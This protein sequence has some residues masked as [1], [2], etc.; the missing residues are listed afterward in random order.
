MPASVMDTSVVHSSDDEFSSTS[1]SE[2]SS[3][4]QWTK[5]TNG[6]TKRKKDAHLSRRIAMPRRKLVQDSLPPS[7]APLAEFNPKV[8][9][10]KAPAWDR[11]L[12]VMIALSTEYPNL[13]IQS[14]RGLTRT[15]IRAKDQASQDT[16][17]S[18]TTLQNKAV[19]FAPQPASITTAYGIVQRVPIAIPTALLRATPSVLEAERMSVWSQA[20][21]ASQPT[22]S[23]KIR[24]EGKLPSKIDIGHLGS[25]S[26][27]PYTPDPIRCYRCQR[28][29]H[30]TRTCHQET[31]TCGICS[32]PHRTT[33]CQEKRRT[34][35]VTPRCSNCKGKH[36]TASKAC[37]VRK[38]RA[39][40]L[41]PKLGNTKQTPTAAKP[42]KQLSQGFRPSMDDFPVAQQAHRLNKPT[43][44]L[45]AEAP[46]LPT[47]QVP[48]AQRGYAGAAGRSTVH[49][50]NAQ[51]AKPARIQKVA[52]TPAIPATP[53]NRKTTTATN[54]TSL[55]STPK[56]SATTQEETET[57]ETC[58]KLLE[59]LFAQLDQLRPLLMVRQKA[60]RN[61]VAKMLSSTQELLGEIIAVM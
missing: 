4:E 43:T 47:F 1:G 26:V 54:K 58:N 46:V 36:S 8:I 31:S 48:S 19:S 37:P 57:A 6:G 23:V 13:K 53:T 55:S 45:P 25:Y 30:T 59:L 15:L 10:I 39:Q 51:A 61:I 38:Q 24:W 22:M 44:K 5:V 9:I 56:V 40:A 27:R 50:Q 52:R 21:Q 28:Y 2:S 41:A 29:G 20:A 11:E 33:V 18:L 60:T 34:E 3:S 16:L 12:S 32:G 35:A 7:N 49:K 14:K 42:A 17:L